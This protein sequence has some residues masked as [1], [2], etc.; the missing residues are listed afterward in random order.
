MHLF[1]YISKICDLENFVADLVFLDLPVTWF[2]INLPE[3]IPQI[4]ASIY[5]TSINAQLTKVPNEMWK[6]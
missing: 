5:I 6:L 4:F 3:S 1:A 2:Y